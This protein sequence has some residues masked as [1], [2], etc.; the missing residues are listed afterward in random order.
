MSVD[1]RP[2]AGR[3]DL[4]AFVELPYRL[5]STSPYWIPPL[6]LERRLFLSPR[7]NAFFDRGEAQLFLA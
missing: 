2:V 5:H 7:F 1:V 3:R 6:R 4:R